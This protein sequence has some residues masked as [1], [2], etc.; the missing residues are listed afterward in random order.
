MKQK[1]NPF[2]KTMKRIM[3]FF[4]SLVVIFGA[5]I[6]AMPTAAAMTSVRTRQAASQK[7]TFPK[8]PA[9]SRAEPSDTCRLRV[10]LTPEDNRGGC[11]TADLILLY[12]PRAVQPSDAVI[13]SGGELYPVQQQDAPGEEGLV[14]MKGRLYRYRRL[15]GY[16]K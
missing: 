2:P 3:A 9:D 4:V 7:R 16:E 8:W 14:D 10:I 15:R 6:P 13:L 5:A 1:Q 11:V 12:A